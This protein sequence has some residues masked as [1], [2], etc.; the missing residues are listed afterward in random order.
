MAT[1]KPE[2][3]RIS[4]FRD[5]IIRAVPRLPNDRASKQAMLQQSLGTLLL[6]FMNWRIRFVPPNVRSITIRQSAINDS[7]WRALKPS[8]DAFLEKVRRGDDITPH[9]SLTALQNGF[10]PATPLK[11]KAV[12][13]WAD[14]DLFLNVMGF[15]HFHLGMSLEKKGI[16]TRT[17]VVLFAH[18]T[19]TTFDVLG[20][21]DHSVFCTDDAMVMTAERR[22]LWELHER[23]ILE[24][25]A[26]GAFVV[27][28]PVSISGH[29]THIVL[30]AQHC[31]KLMKHVDPQLNDRSYLAK[32]I[33]G[34]RLKVPSKPKL[35]WCFK[36]LDLYLADDASGASFLMS[37][38]PP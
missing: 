17:K 14:K 3:K 28:N 23:V 21:F 15:H 25:A 26:P 24:G 19:R 30:L 10:T 1:P 18:V 32:M 29:S 8:T 11:G 27:A 38:G 37:Q 22:R 13:R 34:E 33:Y 9:L 4:K 20:M 7:R 5:G 12:D 6:I 16:V 35:R 36:H 31:A 2:S